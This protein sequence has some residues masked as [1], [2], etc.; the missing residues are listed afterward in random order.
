MRSFARYVARKRGMATALK[1]MLGADTDLFAQ[2][3]QRIQGAISTLVQ[4]AAATGA[5][6]SDVDPV[7]L[8]RAMGGICMATDAPGWEDRTGRLV[9]L[10]MDGLRFGAPGAPR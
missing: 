4:A 10:L 2:S 6:R 8:L 7:D 1:S 5:I 3:Y 9:D